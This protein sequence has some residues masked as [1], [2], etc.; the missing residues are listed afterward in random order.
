MSMREWAQQEI[1]LACQHENPDWK[2][3]EFDY[4]CACYQSALKAYE[5]M[6]D[7]DHSGFS[8]GITAGI[9]KRLLDGYPLIPI[10]DVPEIWVKVHETEKEYQYQCTRLHSLFKT[11]PKDGTAVT[12]SDCESVVCVNE[13]LGCSYTNG[14]ITDLIREKYPIEM[15]YMP[16]GRYV[17]TALDF[18]LSAEPG[19]FDT[20]AIKNVK[21][22]DGTVEELN[23][24]FKENEHSFEPISEDEYNYR[25]GLYEL[26]LA[27]LNKVKESDN[28][29]AEKSE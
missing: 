20:M 23:L 14:F 11:V 12:Y 21:H 1:R 2:E 9:L 18:A 26:N 28:T 15:P 10:E 3:G 25:R 4:G 5:S 13:E 24:Y 29:D 19:V 7:D 27:L 22:P 16:R 8:W 6:L 17:V